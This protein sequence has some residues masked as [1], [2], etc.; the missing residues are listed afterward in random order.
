LV[1]GKI[2]SFIDWVKDKQRQDG[3]QDKEGGIYT[4]LKEYLCSSR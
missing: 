2:F 3:E 1:R 4:D